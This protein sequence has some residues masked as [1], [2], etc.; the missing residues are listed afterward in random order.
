MHRDERAGDATDRVHLS[1]PVM[2]WIIAF[3]VG[4]MAVLLALWSVRLLA[5]MGTVGLVIPGVLLVLAVLAVAEGFWMSTFGFTLTPHEAVVHGVVTRRIR[6]VDIV[7]VRVVNLVG[8]YRV[9]LTLADRRKLRPRAPISSWLPGFGDSY[10]EF[11]G[12]FDTIYRCWQAGRGLPPTGP[13]PPGE[14]QHG[15]PAATSQ[16]PQAPRP[17]GG[18]PA[19]PAPPPPGHGPA[20]PPRYG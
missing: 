10:P 9:E 2:P 3:V 13:P 11:L 19:D 1:P 8:D 20:N 6:W 5:D 15:H 4:G 16:P 17:Q 18:G 14:Q 7:D 12:K